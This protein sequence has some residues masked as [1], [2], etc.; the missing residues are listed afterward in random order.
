MRKKSSLYLMSLTIQD[1]LL[2]IES[3]IAE[4]LPLGVLAKKS[5]YSAWHFQRG[6]KQIAGMSPGVYIRYRRMVM[7]KA[8]L[9]ETHRSITDIALHLG[10]QQQSTFCRVFREHYQLTPRQ[11]R[12]HAQEQT[13]QK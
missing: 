10:Y 5:G 6:F 12:L 2:W 11:Y 8:L 1:I 13:T 7:A 4:P 9:S 3:N